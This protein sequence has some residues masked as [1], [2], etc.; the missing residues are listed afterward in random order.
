[1]ENTLMD[2]YAAGF[3]ISLVVTSFLNA[4]ILIVKEKNDAVM[5][6]MKAVLGHHWT[7]HGAIVVIVFLVLG[8]IFSGMK[9]ETKFDS[10]QMLKYITWAVIISVVII[11]GFFLP[12]LKLAGAMKY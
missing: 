10:R 9:L 6:A 11:A 4:V 7:T 8:F 5:S 2:K 3:G 12:N 1:M